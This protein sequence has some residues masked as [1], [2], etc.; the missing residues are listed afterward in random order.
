MGWLG[1]ITDATGLSGAERDELGALVDVYRKTR[2]RNELI[3][4]Y[5]EGDV[6]PRDIGVD[7]MLQQVKLN[8]ELSCDWPRKA[9]HAL[10]DL[11]RFDGF[12]FEGERDEGL[13]RALRRCG[14]D[15]ALSRHRVGMLKS[16]CMFVTVGK[17]GEHAYARFHS[18]NTGAALMDPTTER[19]RSGFVIAEA[20]TTEWS[21]RKAVPMQ[22]NMHMPGSMV[23]LRR[24]GPGSWAAERAEM[25]KD[26]C[27][28]VPMAYMPTDTKPL[29]GTRINSAVRD[30]VDDVLHLRQT[31]VLSTELYA[32]PMRYI[33]GLTADAMKALKESPKW[34]TYLNPVFTATRDNK[35]NVP[36]VGQLPSNSPAAILDLIYADAKMFASAT[37]IPL[38]SL[39]IVQDNPSSAEAIAEGR[40]DLTDTAQDLIEGQLKPGLREV[41][42]LMMMVEHNVTRDGLTDEQQSVGAK[43][44]N[45]AM[46]SISAATDA[47]MKIATVYP[48]FAGTDVFFE[49]VGFDDE[50][51]KRVRADMRM[52]VARR[53]VTDQPILMGRQAGAAQAETEPQANGHQIA[54]RD[55]D[56]D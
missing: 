35:G 39:G 5:Y 25:P 42:L 47:A 55:T 53:S 17:D 33:V 32:I 15:A 40:K 26:T 24:T 9:V 19:M 54:P 38:N 50:T 36:S 13:D 46:P 16:G 52:N 11:V 10:A 30:L 51:R 27:M 2:R 44:K 1:S 29:G 8:V 31:L 7:T 20:R 23:V 22:L 18:A 21:P 34:A 6:R 49:M 37:G 43:F 48:E 28:M 14:F 12:V 56:A 3:D 45:P 41:A 4:R